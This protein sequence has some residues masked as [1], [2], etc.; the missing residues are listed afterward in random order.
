[1]TTAHLGCPGDPGTVVTKGEERLGAQS[2][3]AEPI[4]HHTEPRVHTAPR[5]KEK[6][7]WAFSWL[8]K[9]FVQKDMGWHCLG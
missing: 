4:V 6:V 7:L 9:H 5:F 3:K 1:M 8:P 2:G